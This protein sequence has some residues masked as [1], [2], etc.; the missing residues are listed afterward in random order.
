MNDPLDFELRN[1]D[2]SLPY[3]LQQ[4]FTEE[5]I[6][7]FGLGLCT[8]GTFAGRIA[9]PLHDQHGRLIGYAGRI[10]YDEAIDAEHP[11]YL[12]PSRRQREGRV[13]EFAKS[14][15][16]YNGHQIQKPVHDLI[17]V[18]GFPSVWWLWQHGHREV[19]ALM[20]SSCS[21]DQAKIIV[22][23]VMRTG[24]IWFLTEAGKGG[25]KCGQNLFN[26]IGPHR[27]C[28]WVKLREGQP[29]DCNLK[30]LNELLG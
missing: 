2:T 18:Q 25:E 28:K 14:L 10:I 7:D 26:E 30:E 11:K 24:R 15:F 9:I 6:R 8:K 29:T 13:L 5:T 4:G 16:V 27:F 23:L 12:Y 3:L 20:G 19:V 22:S 1:L 21:V 17:I